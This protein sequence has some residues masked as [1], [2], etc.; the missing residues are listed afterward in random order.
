[1]KRHSASMD[2]SDAEESTPIGINGSS[3]L[4]PR[5][6]P[7][8]RGESRTKFT[9]PGTTTSGEQQQR[10]V[11][12]VEFTH[13]LDRRVRGDEALA[14]GVGVGRPHRLGKTGGD[15]RHGDSALDPHRRTRRP[16]GDET[17]V[18]ARRGG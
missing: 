9:Q 3:D 17:D 4:S 7:P 6:G 8:A 1:M 5:L 11:E 10:A 12:F 18:R 13:P 14:G 15:D 2:T 16:L